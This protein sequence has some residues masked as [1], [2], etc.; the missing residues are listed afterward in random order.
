MGLQR[1][2]HDWA[3]FTHCI[4]TTACGWLSHWCRSPNEG[5]PQKKKLPLVCCSLGSCNADILISWLGFTWCR[6]LLLPPLSSSSKQQWL[7]AYESSHLAVM[8]DLR[9]HIHSSQK[10]AHGVDSSFI[11]N[12]QNWETDKTSF[13]SMCACQFASVMSDSLWLHGL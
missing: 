12:C 11:R 10:S 7:W 2:R 1:V 9:I 5:L 8:S 13:N 6:H 3:I 4:V